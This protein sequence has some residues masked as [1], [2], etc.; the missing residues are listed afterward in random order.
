MIYIAYFSLCAAARFSKIYVN[1]YGWRCLG[2]VPGVVTNFAIQLA[3]VPL[4][5]DLFYNSF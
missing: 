3:A 4:K 5:N 1:E 2:D